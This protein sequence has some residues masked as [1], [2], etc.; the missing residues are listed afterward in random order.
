MNNGC[1]KQ[2]V[3]NG[4]G[5]ISL[6]EA[7]TDRSCLHSVQI[8]L[9]KQDSR[10]KDRVIQGQNLKIRNV[11]DC[12]RGT[13]RDLEVALWELQESSAYSIAQLKNLKR[14]SI[15]L[16]H[17]HTRY[18]GIDPQFWHTSPGSTVWNTLASRSRKANALGHL[19]SLHLERAG[20]TDYQLAKILTRNPL[21]TEVRL[22]KCFA[23]TDK[24]FKILA[25]SHLRQQLETLHFTNTSSDQIDGRILQHIE[26]FPNLEVL[27]LGVPCFARLICCQCLSLYGCCN[28]DSELVNRL[29]FERWHIPKF[30]PPSTPDRQKEGVEIDDI[31]K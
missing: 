7:T 14:L 28:I 2:Y 3:D 27:C 19:Q 22:R 23:L 5:M 24:T 11:L 17:P 21:L 25:E 1:I 10:T 26:K 13:I 29:N 20:I 30:T 16:D 15:R 12:Y 8:I 18:S 9:P 31:Y 6:M 4:Q